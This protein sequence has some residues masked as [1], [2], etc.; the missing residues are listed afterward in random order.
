M[1]L[2]VFGILENAVYLQTQKAKVIL[3]TAH[4]RVSLHD[5]EWDRNE[6]TAPQPA[7]SVKGKFGYV[8]IAHN[9][10]LFICFHIKTIRNNYTILGNGK[11]FCGRGLPWLLLPQC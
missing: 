1:D 2:T 10:L 4:S 8:G 7:R 5:P 6:N 9:F 3:V 11:K